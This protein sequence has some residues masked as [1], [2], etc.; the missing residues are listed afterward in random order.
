MKRDI[1]KALMDLTDM[2]CEVIAE[3]KEKKHFNRDFAEAVGIV[4]SLAYGRWG[5]EDDK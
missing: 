3:A 2:A 5:N 1:D 4:L